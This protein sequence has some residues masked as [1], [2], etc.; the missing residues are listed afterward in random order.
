V[1]FARG[2]PSGGGPVDLQPT[3]PKK[4]V[5]EKN[6]QALSKT[7]LPASLVAVSRNRIISVRL[8]PNRE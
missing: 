6:T 5:A 1:T 4:I 3:K 2:G 8:K 7:H